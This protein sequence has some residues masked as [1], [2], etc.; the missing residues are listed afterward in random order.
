ALAKSHEGASSSG[1]SNPAPPSLMKLFENLEYRL[2][3]MKVV[4]ALH[5]DDINMIGICGTI[6]GGDTMT[7]KEFIQIVKHQDIFEEVV[8]AV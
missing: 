3:Y 1:T 4:N 8:M 2:P 6:K 7:A 5:N